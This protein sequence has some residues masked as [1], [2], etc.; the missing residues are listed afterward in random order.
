MASQF[1]RAVVAEAGTDLVQLVEV[2]APVPAD[3]VVLVDVSLISVNRGELH[4]LRDAKPGWRPGWDFAGTVVESRCDGTAFAPGHRVFGIAVNGGA[5]AERIAVRADQLA[6]LPAALGDEVAAALPVAA[7]TARRVLR[8]AGELRGRR[9]LVT[10]AAGGVGRFA[11]QLAHAAGA[12][13]TAVVRNTVRA[14]GLT[15]LGADHVLTDLDSPTHG[16]DVVLESVGGASLERALDLV[17]TDGL[18]VTFGNSAR[19]SATLPVAQ[20][21]P[22]Q[23]VLRGYYLL[24]DIIRHPSA[25]DLAELADR[26]ARGRLQVDID[27]VRHID[28]LPEVLRAL[29]ERRVAGKAVL[30]MR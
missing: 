4:R 17:A 28:A 26:A 14:E 20:F 1:V 15:Q 19:T 3:G 27:T 10:G 5:W 9:V 18:V 21:Y 11:I 13:V 8:L 22:K 6:P 16:F 29:A 7:V 2:P 12:E 25:R 23:A 24:D 30:R